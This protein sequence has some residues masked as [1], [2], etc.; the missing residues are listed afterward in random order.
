MTTPIGLEANKQLM[1]NKF[2]LLTNETGNMY[3]AAYDAYYN[4]ASKS[5]NA[6]NVNDVD[7]SDLAPIVNAK[8]QEMETQLKADANQFAKDL[9]SGISE[10]LNEISMQIDAHCKSMIINIITTTPGASGSVLASPVGPVTGTI[11][12]NN[13]SPAGGITIS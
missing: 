13:L 2:R 3:K 7:D 6:L 12:A 4:L 5:I 9:C 1:D 8:K 10:V 11:A